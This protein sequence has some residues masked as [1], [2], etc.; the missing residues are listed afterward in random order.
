MIIKQVFPIV[1]ALLLSGCAAF[2]SG[3]ITDSASLGQANFSYENQVEGVANA[4]Y[5]FGIGGLGRQALVSEAK[6]QM[7]LEEPLGD[8][9]AYANITVNWKTSYIMFGLIMNV[10]CTVTADIVKFNKASG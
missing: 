7:R 6:E 2:H 1:L 4:T 8:N 5:V 10:K 3:Y 9:E